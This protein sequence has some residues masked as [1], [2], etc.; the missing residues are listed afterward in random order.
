MLRV[1]TAITGLIITIL[2]LISGYICGATAQ[3][4]QG[5]S[6]LGPAYVGIMILRGGCGIGALLAIISLFARE[7]ETRIT[8]A[9]CLVLAGFGLLG[10]RFILGM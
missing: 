8:A 6:A 3:A 1:G 10:S 7:T 9:I 5:F 4:A 2:S